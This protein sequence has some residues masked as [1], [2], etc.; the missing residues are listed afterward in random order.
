MSVKF[1]YVLLVDLTP[2][3]LVVSCKIDVRTPYLHCFV[4]WNQFVTNTAL[5]INITDKWRN[6]R[7]FLLFDLVISDFCR[8]P[9]FLSKVL[10]EH[11]AFRWNCQ[12]IFC[13]KCF[14][15]LKLH[16]H[17]RSIAHEIQPETKKLSFC[18]WNLI[19]SYLKW[20]SDFMPSS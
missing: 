2:S 14:Y 16:F 19:N 11:Y 17:P 20:I 15:F 3:L 4:A 9:C 12:T 8:L 1:K 7:L 13:F 5:S 6:H 18:R 10:L